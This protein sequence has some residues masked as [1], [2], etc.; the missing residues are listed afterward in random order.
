MKI[1]LILL[2]AGAGRRFGSDKL[3]AILAERALYEHAVDC[4]AEFDFVRKVIV[5]GNPRI[6]DYAVAAGFVPVLN[7][8]PEVGIARSIHLG[9]AA[10]SDVRPDGILFAVSDQP[11]VSKDSVRRL[12][13]AFCAAKDGRANAALTMGDVVGNPTVI[14]A[15]YFDEL[16]AL[17]G[18]CGGKRIIMKYPDR[19]IRVPVADKRELRDVDRPA[20][21]LQFN[22]GADTK[23]CG[24]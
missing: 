17:T 6:R 11:A 14:G 9:M 12:L 22:D 21:L 2:A 8:Q 16:A 5:T 10:L 23:G 13:A 7:E 1:G 4:Y 24:W 19:L 3:S 20:D 18:D 15:A